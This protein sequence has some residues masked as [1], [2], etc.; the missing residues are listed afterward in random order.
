[1]Q[2]DS[3]KTKTVLIVNAVDEKRCRGIG[4]GEHFGTAIASGPSR[5]CCKGYEPP[6][7]PPDMPSIPDT[8]PARDSGADTPCRDHDLPGHGGGTLA[9]P[10]AASRTPP[11]VRLSSSVTVS[12][13][14]FTRSSSSSSSISSSMAFLL[15]ETTSTIK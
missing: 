8:A 13:H 4:R 6:P 9:E 15:Y 2:M 14:Q 3:R 5:R 10:D 11:L 7:T 1:M 12:V